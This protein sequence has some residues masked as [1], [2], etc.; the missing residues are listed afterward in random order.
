VTRLYPLACI[1][2]ANRYNLALDVPADRSYKDAEIIVPGGANDD[3]VMKVMP[4]NPQHP[5]F[6]NLIMKI[7]KA[8]GI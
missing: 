7:K 6:L 5:Y 4:A 2:T 8:W 3:S 1:L